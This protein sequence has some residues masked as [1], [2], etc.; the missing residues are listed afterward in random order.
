MLIAI[1]C[2]VVKYLLLLFQKWDSFPQTDFEYL[3]ET[4]LDQYMYKYG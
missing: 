2:R 3:F 4:L 1:F